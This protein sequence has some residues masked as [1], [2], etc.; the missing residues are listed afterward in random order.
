MKPYAA[1]FTAAEVAL[2]RLT[3]ERVRE[4]I[5]D[6][7]L[8]ASAYDLTGAQVRGLLCLLEVIEKAK[9]I[10]AQPEWSE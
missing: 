5:I 1:V 7:G 2:A 10:S 4:Q 8:D 9:P 6:N 3:C